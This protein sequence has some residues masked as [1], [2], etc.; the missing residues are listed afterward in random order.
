[1]MSDV[2]M[3]HRKMCDFFL[4][5]LFLFNL[6]QKLRNS[7]FESHLNIVRILDKKINRWCQI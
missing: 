1:M 3:S 5:P 6:V 7:D 2:N 4:F